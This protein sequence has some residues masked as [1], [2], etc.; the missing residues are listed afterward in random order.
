MALGE[1]RRGNRVANMRGTVFTPVA[2][3]EGFAQEFRPSES[4]P[5]GDDMTGVGANLRREEPRWSRPQRVFFTLGAA[6]FCWAVPIAAIYWL[7]S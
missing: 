6:V 4:R 7:V 2:S 1:R 5:D 3:R